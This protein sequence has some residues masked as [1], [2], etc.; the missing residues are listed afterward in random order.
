MAERKSISEA[1]TRRPRIQHMQKLGGDPVPRHRGAGVKPDTA[2]HEITDPINAQ[3]NPWK[4]YR[5]LGD[6]VQGGVLILGSKMGK[7]IMFKE[8]SK[9][10]GRKEYSMLQAIKH[11]NVIDVQAVYIEDTCFFLGL[12]YARCTLEEVISVPLEMGEK[13]VQCVAFSVCCAFQRPNT[14]TD[15][16]QLFG[17][18]QS[19]AAA[20]IAH[21]NI[22]VQSVR[23]CGR[24]GRVILCLNLCPLALNL[25]TLLKAI[26]NVQG[27]LRGHHRQRISSYSA[28]CSC[29]V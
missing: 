12:E 4:E 3:R 29:N 13:H 10:D 14:I 16:G 15:F 25:L 8:M 23:L 17:A 7:T 9:A 28:S 27:G 18:I 11:R 26:S 20:G 2:V 5:R 21:G 22:N 24:T 1:F 6:L 19:I